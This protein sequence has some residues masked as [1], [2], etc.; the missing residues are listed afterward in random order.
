MTLTTQGP[1][2]SHGDE[3]SRAHDIAQ[4]V[5]V[6][7]GEVAVVAVAALH[8][9]IDAVQVQSHVLQQLRLT[10]AIIGNVRER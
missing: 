9:L 5:E 4:L 6:L 3:Y 8:V 7:R 2:G 10:W 1:V